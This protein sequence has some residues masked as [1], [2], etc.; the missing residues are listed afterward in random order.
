MKNNKL[1]RRGFTMVEV[2]LVVTILGILASVVTPYIKDV[3]VKSRQ[4]ATMQD[5]IGLGKALE[6]YRIDY[7]Y[8]PN[9]LWELRPVYLPAS[10]DL[11][12]SWNRN[13]LYTPDNN[14]VSV[15]LY[16]GLNINGYEL[17]SL[18]SDT[19]TNPFPP[20]PWNAGFANAFY[21]IVLQNGVFIQKPQ[22]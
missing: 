19:A 16:T 8:Y 10:A 6:A 4:G 18:G 1:K 2:A 12:D 11:Q 5:M 22:F 14:G 9:F 20:I 15:S 21:D 17:V 13:Y 3:M 7:G